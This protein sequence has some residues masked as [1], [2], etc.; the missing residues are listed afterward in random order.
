MTSFR[1]IEQNPTKDTIYWIEV[2]VPRLPHSKSNMAA[3]GCP[4]NV[5]V[6]VQVIG[7]RA[8]L[9]QAEVILLGPNDNTVCYV[10]KCQLHTREG[11]SF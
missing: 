5:W 8:D 7:Y 3:K 2:V 4:S 10:A 11:M 9:E 6:G 1:Q